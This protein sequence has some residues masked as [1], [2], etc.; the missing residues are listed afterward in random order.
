M[1]GRRDH[2][3]KSSASGKTHEG[4]PETISGVHALG[5]LLK[6]RVNDGMRAVCTYGLG[7][8]FEL[9]AVAAG[10]L[11]FRVSRIGVNRRESLSSEASCGSHQTLVDPFGHGSHTRLPCRHNQTA[12]TKVSCFGT[13]DSDSLKVGKSRAQE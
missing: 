5:P 2:T 6:T 9:P 1:P 3:R 7:K 4:L 10:K 8:V 11:R 13:T 12:V